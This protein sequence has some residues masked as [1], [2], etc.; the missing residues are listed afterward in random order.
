MFKNKTIYSAVISLVASSTVIAA[1]KKVETIQTLPD[2]EVVHSIE[3]QIKEW[4]KRP[5]FV[6]KYKLSGTVESMDTKQIDERV[7]LI[8]VED[9][10]KY[11]PSVEVRQRFSG[12][13]N[14]PMGT[15]TASVSQSARTMIYADGILLSNYMG[16]N[17]G[18]TGSP[19]WNVVAPGE[20]ERSDLI[21]GPFSAQYAGN[22][23]GGVLVMTT[24]MPKKFEAGIN[25]MGTFG[26]WDVYNQNGSTNMQNYAMY[27]GNKIDDFSF[28]FDYNHLYSLGQPEAW[29]TVATG[30]GTAPNSSGT[31]VNG[32][33]S[34][35]NPYGAPMYVTGYNN[36]QFATTQNNMKLKLAYDI[37]EHVRLSYTIGLWLNN[38]TANA[39]STLTNSSTGAD[40]YGTTPIINNLQYST[41]VFTPNLYQQRN[42]THGITLK[43]DTGGVFDWELVG[44]VVNMGL[45]NNSY[46]ATQSPYA[47]PNATGRTNNLS[48]SNWYTVD[49]KGI[50]RTSDDYLG[51]HEV[52][53]G[54]HNDSYQLNN[55][56]YNTTSW[57]YGTPT[58]LNSNSQGQ[59]MT[60]GYWAQDALEFNKQ[61]GLTLGGRVEHWDAYN[62]Y[63]QVATTG[64]VANTTYKQKD[65]QA[66]NFS[67]KVQLNWNPNVDWRVGASFGV[68]YRYPTVTELFQTTTSNNQVIN[69]NPNLQ[70]EH[71]ISSELATEYFMSNGKAR[72]SFFTQSV[73]NA[74]YGVNTLLSNGKVSSTQQN[75][76][77]TTQYGLEFS[78]EF[79]DV[80]IDKLN[81]YATAT[82]TQAKI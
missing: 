35:T 48:A 44:S 9:A 55:P 54:F 12:D 37:T 59:T 3:D 38:A 22:S 62:G 69:G 64:T 36:G 49:A 40:Y 20:L 47:Y 1:D 74:I 65:Q 71:S 80:F 41:T 11:L 17:N 33:V 56:V 77:L 5:D 26:T 78:N 13:T 25:A 66:L 23:M 39:D 24:K 46:G 16:N 52:S 30:A 10:I 29:N 82:W 19:L 45:Y 79:K 67:P 75:I 58:T 27:F 53:F 51:K 61:W 42:W 4:K 81:F 7:N 31:R 18:A 70:A 72:L 60:Q 2:V 28:R 50:W 68:A 14:E 73:N 34:A 21:Y 57:Q 32:A 8:T 76:P 63:N 43:Q 6:E 15:R